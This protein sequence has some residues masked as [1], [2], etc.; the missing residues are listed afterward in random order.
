MCSHRGKNVA[1]VSKGLKGLKMLEFTKEAASAE[2]LLVAFDQKSFLPQE[3]H[4]AGGSVELSVKNKDVTTTSLA[5]CTGWGLQITTRFR[6]P[7][8]HLSGARRG[9]SQYV[10]TRPCIV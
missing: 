9:A 10:C 4:L 5:R 6:P 1:T 8:G 7:S 2:S 3:N